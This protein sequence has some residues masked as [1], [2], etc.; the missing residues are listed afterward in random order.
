MHSYYGIHGNAEDDDDNNSGVSS[1]E[2]EALKRDSEEDLV[3]DSEEG[4]VAL[5]PPLSVMGMERDPSQNDPS[6]FEAYSHVGTPYNPFLT[7]QNASCYAGTYAPN[8]GFDDPVHLQLPPP[9]YH[10]ANIPQG[11][12][13]PPPG[14][15]NVIS[16]G[17]APG[18]P[19]GMP[20][21][22]LRHAEE[23]VNK[24][25]EYITASAFHTAMLKAWGTLS[26]E[27]RLSP[28]ALNSL[29]LNTF[30]RD[31]SPTGPNVV[32][33]FNW[34]TSNLQ[35]V[36][37]RGPVVVIL[38]ADNYLNWKIFITRKI[39]ENGWKDLIGATTHITVPP[40]P[41]I[42][43]ASREAPIP[44]AGSAID[45]H[46]PSNESEDEDNH[47]SLLSRQIACSN[48]ILQHVDERYWQIINPRERDPS[49]MLEEIDHVW[50]T[51]MAVSGRNRFYLAMSKIRIGSEKVFDFMAQFKWL[52]E[53]FLSEDGVLPK[54]KL[55]ELLFKALEPR[56][57]GLEEMS[58]PGLEDECPY[59]AHHEFLGVLD[60]MQTYMK[61][62]YPLGLEEEIMITRVSGE[63]ETK[64]GE[65]EAK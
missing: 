54:E 34:E 61:A 37:T 18:T 42:R 57:P 21:Q 28:G 6:D 38:N 43:K 31:P 19:R 12:I 20:S 59:M 48:F 51:M 50:G 41:R 60:F 40:G 27:L 64:P 11:P 46:T 56:F 10:P 35:N 8:H 45:T 63:D 29:G 24:Q 2:L 58:I 3:R 36:H 39:E 49:V 15:Y 17:I 32:P 5:D 23:K 14:F 47:T 13:Q 65:S 25:V 26:R 9:M 55:K 33:F 4:G 1:D 62:E 16:P 7:S 52:Y 53:S 44:D 22:T 30:D